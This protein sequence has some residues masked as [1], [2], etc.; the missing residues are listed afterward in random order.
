MPAIKCQFDL[1][2]EPRTAIVVEAAGREGVAVS[3]WD[4]CNVG[5][6]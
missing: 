4:Y 6:R 3:F 2:P 5:A 1:E